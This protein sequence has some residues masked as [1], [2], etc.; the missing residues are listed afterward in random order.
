MEGGA[1][2]AAPLFCTKKCKLS[3][4]LWSTI[5]YNEITVKKD[6]TSKAGKSQKGEKMDEEMTS[7][8][9]EIVLKMIIQI[10]K[11]SKDKDEA[12]KKI[13]ALLK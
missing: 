1:A 2:N 12:I 11:D 6:L 3:L 9:L 8:E 5:I 4:D 13:E 7:K 10:I